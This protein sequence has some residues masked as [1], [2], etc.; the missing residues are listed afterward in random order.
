MVVAHF[1]LCLLSDLF[2]ISSTG[3]TMYRVWGA[4]VAA[5]ISVFGAG[6]AFAFGDVC[7]KDVV[8]RGS[9]EGSMS[10]ARNAAIAA[11][12]TKV[13]TLHGPRFANWWYSGDRAV[14]C[15]WNKKGNRI[16]CN[17]VAIPCARKR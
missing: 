6:E 5:G 3:V 11:W 8:A 14:E 15:S 12:E 4:A 17:A 1:G 10:K 7:H 9:V 13:A 16:W 2:V